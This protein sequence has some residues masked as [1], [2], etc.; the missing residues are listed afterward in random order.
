MLAVFGLD[1][2]EGA[3]DRAVSAGRALICAARA[4]AAETGLPMRVGVGVHVGPVVAGTIGSADRLEFTVIG[5]TVNT[6]ARLESLT[7][8]LGVD[9]LISDATREELTDGGS[10]VQSV[11][12]RALRGRSQTLGVFAVAV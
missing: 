12:E 6:A 3:A 7:K 11:G 2:P 1:A 5:D 8:E 9:L 4:L 10:A